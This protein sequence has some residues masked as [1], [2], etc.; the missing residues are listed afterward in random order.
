METVQETSEILILA[1]VQLNIAHHIRNGCPIAFNGTG[2][3][4]PL[5]EKM[6]KE[7][8]NLVHRGRLEVHL[9]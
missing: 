3:Q 9:V 2:L 7:V 8:R 1:D 5:L 6:Q 4:I